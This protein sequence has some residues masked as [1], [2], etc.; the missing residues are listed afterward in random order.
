M[1]YLFDNNIAPALADAL[2]LL[3]KPVV[4]VRDISSLGAAAPDDAILDHAAQWGHVLVTRDRDLRHSAHY[5][6]VLATRKLVVVFVNTGKARQLNAWQI[7]QLVVRGWD[8]LE[9]F[10]ATS[11]RP[12]IGLMQ[13]NGRV[14]SG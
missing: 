10:V 7:A 13:Q 9:R 11:K 1:S 8:N 14:V 2:K 5:R 12:L 4:H 6:A 3:S